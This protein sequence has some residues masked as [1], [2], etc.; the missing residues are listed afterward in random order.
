M[1][2][3]TAKGRHPKVALAARAI[4]R[5]AN[6][7]HVDSTAPSADRAHGTDEEIAAGG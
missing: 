2:L 7:F 6:R 4:P 3:R 5:R 1:R